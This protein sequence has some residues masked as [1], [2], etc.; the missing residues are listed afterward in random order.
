MSSAALQTWNAARR[1]RLDELYAAHAAVGP[2]GPGRRTATEQIN[3]SIVLILAA[4][5]QGFARDLHNEAVDFVV[6]RMAPHNAAWESNLRILLT[7]NRKLERGNARRN[8]IQDDYALL[9]F[10]MLDEVKSRYANGQD[11]LTKLEAILDLRNDIAH[12][13]RAK[14]EAAFGGK[15]LRLAQVKAW[16]ASLRALARAMDV[17]TADSLEKVTKAGRP[18]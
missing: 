11:W 15:Q 8:A 12:G 9:G 3:L 16:D 17:I 5:F 18:W 13:D 4:E 1:A 7:L 10:K 14:V 2:S 6:G